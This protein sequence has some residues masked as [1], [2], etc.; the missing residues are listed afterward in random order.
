MPVCNFRLSHQNFL[1]RLI[2][3]LPLSVVSEVA[4]SLERLLDPSAL[5]RG[6]HRDFQHRFRPHTVVDGRRVV[7][8]QREERGERCN[9]DVQLDAGFSGNKVFPGHGRYHGNFL[10]VCH[11]WHDKFNRNHIRLRD[12]A[13]NEGQ[14]RR[15]D[16][17]R[18]VRDAN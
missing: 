3:E 12:G 17:D 1:I 18:V 14:K 11:I 9:R 5:V 15:G 10:I 8:E 2:C 13:G 4:R 6:V 7:H 16:S